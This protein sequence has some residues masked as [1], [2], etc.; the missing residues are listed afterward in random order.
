VFLNERPR[1]LDR[2]VSFPGIRGAINKAASIGLADDIPEL[3]AARLKE[4]DVAIAHATEVIK[5]TAGEVD[6]HK[7]Q[8]DTLVGQ[9]YNRAAEKA[10]RKMD[11]SLTQKTEAEGMMQ[12]HEA[13]QQASA[14]A[15]EAC[16]EERRAAGRPETQLD[17]DLEGPKVAAPASS[18]D[19][20]DDD[21]GDDA[22]A[23]ER[24]AAVKRRREAK[25]A[26]K[27][28]AFV[29]NL[30]LEEANRAAARKRHDE[31]ASLASA[32]AREE[33]KRSLA[34]AEKAKARERDLEK[35]RRRFKR[36]RDRAAAL[37]AAEAKTAADLLQRTRS[38]SK[39]GAY[40]RPAAEY[41]D[42]KDVASAQIAVDVAMA[43]AELRRCRHAGP[44]RQRDAHG[45]HEL[46]LRAEHA[47]ELL[48]DLQRVEP[49]PG[50]QPPAARA[51]VELKSSTRLQ[52]V[53]NRTV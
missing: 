45:P 28:R 4:H 49:H 9:G 40:V 22:A 46:H 44:L 41:A 23:L 3:C 12:F 50:G 53:L 10:R 21:H 37:R 1:P 42:D 6:L 38:A 33:E 29:A 14:D 18:S 16:L 48:P 51:C 39:L 8:Y 13:Q 2:P 24:R 5:R 25:A 19:D 35:A 20:D 17:E 36:D 47:H 34:A 31:R 43:D 15:L 26:E 27:A 52:C 30:E 11:A 7:E 32:L